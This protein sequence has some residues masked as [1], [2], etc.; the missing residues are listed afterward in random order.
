MNIC[1]GVKWSIEPITDCSWEAVQ[2][3]LPRVSEQRR[4]QALLFKHAF[5]QYACLK[6]YLMLQDLLREHYGIEGDLLFTYNEYGK[7][8][9]SRR[10]SQNDMNDVASQPYFSISHCKKAIAVAVDTMPI[11]IDIETIRHP[12]K[13]LIEKTMNTQE[14]QQIATSEN[15]DKEFTALWT[16]KEAVLKRYGTGIIDDLHEV[17]SNLENLQIHT[18]RSTA[19]TICTICTHQ[20]KI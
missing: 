20:K 17:L 12:S 6:A 1:D 13:S 2:E 18:F 19:D 4:A 14:Q 16:R 15:P 5:G 10:G 3:M 8:M 9:L 11:G 7:P